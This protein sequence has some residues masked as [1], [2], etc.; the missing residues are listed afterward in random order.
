MYMCVT[1]RHQACVLHRKNIPGSGSVRGLGVKL[2]QTVSNGADAKTTGIRCFGSPTAKGY[3]PKKSTSPT[4]DANAKR[5]PP[6]SPHRAAPRRPRA[7]RR[8][9]A[10]HELELATPPASSSPLKAQ[11]AGVLPLF[12]FLLATG[13][14]NPPVKFTAAAAPPPDSLCLQHRLA[15]A[16]AVRV[17]PSLAHTLVLSPPLALLFSGGSGCSASMAGLAAVPAPPPTPR[18]T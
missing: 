12:P 4:S 10:S 13:R 15:P 18:R 17:L 3:G 11:A 7:R 8:G 6:A 16:P 5:A 14:L 1:V 9:P 2:L